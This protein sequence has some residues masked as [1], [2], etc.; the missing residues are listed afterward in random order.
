MT[1]RLKAAWILLLAC[2]ILPCATMARNGGSA[3]SEKSRLPVTVSRISI[4]GNKAITTDE[5][6]GIMLTTTRSS[7]LGTGLFGGAPRPYIPEDF[8]K[9]VVLIRKLYTFKGYFST[10]VDTTVVHSNDRKKVSLFIRV[11]ENQPSRVDQLSYAG[12]ERLPEELRSKY[13]SRSSIKL[14]E[15]FSVEKIIQERDRTLEFFR[16]YGYAQFHPDSIKIKVDTVGLNAGIHVRLSLPDQV[17]YGPVNVVVHNPLRKDDESKSRSFM[18]DSISV[19]IYGRQKLLDNIF[20]HS[21]AYRPG[22]LTQH[23]LEQRTMQNF[24]STNLFS[25][26]SIDSDS[27]KADT[28]YTTIHLSPSPKHLIEPKLLVDNRYGP[29]FIGT[30]LAYENRNLLGGAEQFRISADYGTQTTTQNSL[31]GDMAAADYDHARLYDMNVKANLAMPVLKKQGALL[32]VTTEYSRSTLPVLLRSRKEL[33]RASYS[34]PLSSTSRLNFDFFEIEVAQKDSLR[35]FRQLFTSQLAQNIGI[36]PNDAAAVNHGIDSLLQKRVNQTFRLQYNFTNRNKPSISRRTVWNVAATAEESGSLF[37]FIDKYIDTSNYPDFTS[38]DPQI[39]G[40]AY[41]QYVKLD[42]QLSFARDLSPDRQFA[43]RLSLGWMSP[44]GK[45]NTTPED[46][47][48]YAGGSN[49]M[50]GWL[51]NTLGPGNSKSKAVSNFGADIKLELG[52]EYRMKLFKL[53]GQPSGITLFTDIGNIWDRTGPYAFSLSSLRKDFAWDA[54]A[55]LRVGS[56]IGPFRFDFAWKVHDPAAPDPWQITNWDLKNL[57]FNFG[58][59]E[60]F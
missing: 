41:S 38:S 30:S 16:D 2:L 42:T 10:T 24:G 45:S 43:G 25:S 8:D 14:K 23:S 33:V 26:I 20:I 56:P 49:S 22:R 51:F 52:M 1:S 47:R 36:N 46:R 59:G 39:F 17:H 48:F 9:D 12:L 15:V 58:I 5:I 40:I 54:G 44:Y 6:R 37:W 27:L 11:H 32:N 19:K 3:S 13:M 34:T 7:F 31:V 28:L 4:R 57:T 50:R 60:A 29:L 21:V 35:G 55:G 53:F 18:R